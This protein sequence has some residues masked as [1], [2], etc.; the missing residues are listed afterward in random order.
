MEQT[1][2]GTLDKDH[3]RK[4]ITINL[5][6]CESISDELKGLLNGPAAENQ[7]ALALTADVERVR[8]ALDSINGS[9][10]TISSGHRAYWDGLVKLL[11]RFL[12]DLRALRNLLRSVKRPSVIFPMY[13]W[14]LRFKRAEEEI[15][16]YHETIE[17]YLT[18]V[19]VMAGVFTI[20]RVQS[21]PS[22][23]VTYEDSIAFVNSVKERFASEPQV[24]MQFLEILQI[25]QRENLPLA[26]VF[27]RVRTL[28]STTPD[29]LESFRGFMP[30]F[31]PRAIDAVDSNPP[32]MALDSAIRDLLIDQRRPSSGSTTW[33]PATSARWSSA[34]D[35]SENFQY[36]TLDF[37]NFETRFVMCA[38]GQ[39]S[40]SASCELMHASLLNAPEYVALSYCWLGQEASKQIWVNGGSHWITANL[41]LALDTL[42]ENG[43]Q[44]IWADALC[45]NQSDNYE[46]SHQ[47]ARMGSI[48]SQAAKVIVWLGESENGSDDAMRSLIDLASTPEDQHALD[49]AL[50][51]K[52]K[53]VSI[54]QREYW[55]RGWILQEISKAKVCMPAPESVAYH[56]GCNFALYAIMAHSD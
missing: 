40:K 5:R 23:T 14:V 53:I 56:G 7:T 24:Y 25:Y 20:L 16:A 44:K 1:A 48:Y 29:L 38:G 50:K 32:P 31:E 28:F 43:I 35:S 37:A 27:E 4:L 39:F 18:A 54:L 55:A 26:D 21:D 8:Q 30:D 47:V 45:I 33:S 10:T 2:A 42:W 22:K 6:V 41:Q 36:Q 49:N 51:Q 17:T 34:S 46:R 9:S 19:E 12:G 15:H 11:H 3:G 52:D 13:R